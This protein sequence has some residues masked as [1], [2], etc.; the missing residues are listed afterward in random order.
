MFAT[1]RLHFSARTSTIPQ[2]PFQRLSSSVKQDTPAAA[3]EFDAILNYCAHAQTWQHV[4]LP[5]LLVSSP[6]YPCVPRHATLRESGDETI[7]FLLG[8]RLRIARANGFL[9][10]ESTSALVYSTAAE[11]SRIHT[12]YPVAAT[13]WSCLSSEKIRD[14]KISTEIK[15]IKM[16][17]VETKNISK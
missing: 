7:G 9:R 2:N 6:D 10:R 3:L 4:A 16:T 17:Q 1:N 13:A 12:S 11:A 8:T 15:N 5:W 14:K